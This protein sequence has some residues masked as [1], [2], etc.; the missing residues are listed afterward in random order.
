MTFPGLARVGVSVLAL[1]AA[2]PAAAQEA[3]VLD[4]LVFSGG[5]TPITADSFGRSVR[6]IDTAEIAE[7][8]LDSV[9]A[10]LRAV[11]GVTVSNGGT[12]QLRIRGSEDNH[13]LILVDGVEVQLPSSGYYELGNLMLSDI[14]RIEVLKG[15]QSALYGANAAGGVISITTLRGDVGGPETTAFVEL[16]TQNT[17]AAGLSFRQSGE[18]LDIGLSLARRTSDGFDL[19]NDVGGTPDKRDS[20]SLTLNGTYRVSDLVTLDFGFRALERVE[21]YDDLTFPF[22]IANAK[23]DYVIDA[24]N[25]FRFDTERQGH[26][27]LTVAGEG[28]RVEHALRFARAGG[29]QQFNAFT[30]NDFSR[31]QLQY[32]ATIGL[33]G[34]LD[35]ARHTL[36]ALLETETETLQ[37]TSSFNRTTRSGALE[38]RAAFE[39]GLDVQA[40]LRFDDNESFADSRT[41]NLGLSYALGEDTRLRASAGT[42]VVNPTLIEQFGFFN[43]YIANPNLTPERSFGADVGIEHRFWDGRASVELT[44]FSNTITDR[45]DNQTV[46]GNVQPVNLAGESTQRGA[47]LSLSANLFDGLDAAL[48]YTYLDARDP[49]GSQTERK[50]RHTVTL[51]LAVDAFD[52]RGRFGFNVRH[53]AGMVDEDQRTNVNV[54]IADY[55]VVGLTGSYDLTD[56]AQLY[57]RIDNLLDATYEEN[58]GFVAPRR[59][60]AFGVRTR[61]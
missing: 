38:Y 53:V 60:L 47:E 29:T 55:S 19:S 10:L 50:P 37:N 27:G 30:P 15:P 54:P 42:G 21:G 36:T 35:S 45:I 41:W 32:R 48:G 56:K 26:L 7:S 59:S 14:A 25:N 46:G 18:R 4:E 17:Q 8:G 2:A 3:F 24:P 13:T 1:A 33:D 34:T 52:G 43:N 51:A 57:G 28:G 6:V 49:N 12:N 9:S 61:F 58:W 23:A 31:S 39:G 40:G 20:A 44:L 22:G 11:P 16:G 5:L